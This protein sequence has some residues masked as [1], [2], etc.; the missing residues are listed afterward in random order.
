MFAIAPHKGAG[1][2]NVWGRGSTR[3]FPPPNYFVFV[4]SRK[5]KREPA[6]ALDGGMHA[7][8]IRERLNSG[9]PTGACSIVLS[10]AESTTDIS[11]VRIVPVAIRAPQVVWI[12][13]PRR[14]TQQPQQRARTDAR[15]LV[16]PPSADGTHPLNPLLLKREGDFQSFKPALP[17]LFPREGGRGDEL[18]LLKEQLRTRFQKKKSP[19]SRG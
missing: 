11:V 19:A 2:Q 1:L 10:T 14:P 3:Y 15:F 9:M 13:G 12:I 17:L 16:A 8:T 18:R 7:P 6:Q 5:A 4:P